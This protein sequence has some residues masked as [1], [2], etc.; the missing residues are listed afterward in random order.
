MK[1]YMKTTLAPFLVAAAT[2]STPSLRG[3][4]GPSQLVAR[5][6]CSNPRDT[7][8]GYSPGTVATMF[9]LHFD[10]ADGGVLLKTFDQYDDSFNYGYLKTV[11]ATWSSPAGGGKTFVGV[12]DNGWIDGTRRPL[13]VSFYTPTDG[14]FVGGQLSGWLSEKI[15]NGTCT[16]AMP[17]VPKPELCCGDRCV[18]SATIPF[19]GRCDYTPGLKCVVGV[20]GPGGVYNNVGQCMGTEQDCSLC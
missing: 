16:F 5:G 19:I 2:A 11:N 10:V 9:S 14:S 3:T 4:A 18:M 7:K 8:F 12:V 15:P 1:I 6:S 13:A 17:A 20:T